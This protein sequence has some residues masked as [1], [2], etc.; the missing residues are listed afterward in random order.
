MIVPVL[1]TPLAQDFSVTE[2]LFWT[3]VVMALLVVG[4]LAAMRV[5]KWL[6]EDE[7][8]GDHPGLT[9][10]DLRRFHRAGK[11][12]DEEFEKA[13]IL[14]IAS[15]QQAT[16]RAVAEAAAAARKQGGSAGVE[17]LRER[18]RRNKL[19]ADSARN[20]RNRIS[21]PAPKRMITRNPPNFRIYRF[22]VGKKF[23]MMPASS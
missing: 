11:M 22:R 21:D 15:T 3:L 13:R 19:A 10:G 1:P 8:G 4:F 17:E 23:P 5:R 7:E 20:R 6:M 2:H 14:M 18:A 12:T 16:D 9:L